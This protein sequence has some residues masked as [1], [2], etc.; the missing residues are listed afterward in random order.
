MATGE[1][2]PVALAALKA[3]H[4]YRN[5]DFTKKQ[6]MGFPTYGIPEQIRTWRVER[7]ML[8]LPRGG[9]KR[10]RT[11]LRENNLAFRVI[12]GRSEGTPPAHRLKYKGLP[13]REH[14]R[15]MVRVG[16]KDEQCIL[17]GATG[18]GK[19]IAAFALAAEIGL[20]TL[21]V[22]PNKALFKQWAHWADKVLGLRGDELG[23][24]GDG[25][26]RLRTLTIAIQDTLG[27]WATH[28]GI[29][30]DVSEF[31]GAII[32]D[33]I[34]RAAANTLYNAI[35][36]MPCR[37]RIGFSASEKRKD[38]KECLIYDLFSSVGYEASRSEMTAAGHILD[39][40]FRLIPT[41]FR[42]DWYG[43]DKGDLDFN[44]LLDEMTNDAKRNELAYRFIDAELGKGE[45]VL[46]FTHRREHA[47]DV[48]R[49][50]VGQ[51]VPSG[52]ML[53]DGEPGDAPE[54]DRTKAGIESGKVRCA[55]GTYSAIGVG[56]D[57]PAVGVGFALTPIHTNEQ[58][59][60]QVRGRLCRP[61][62]EAGKK[63]GCLYA[64]VDI[65]VFGLQPIRN[66]VSWNQ[67]VSVWDG[68]R[69]VDAKAYLKSKSKRGGQSFR[70]AS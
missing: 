50:F 53:G 41:S 48:D 61:N 16:M 64:L 11:I 13:L 31:F 55:I 15:E 56:I 4:E 1:L 46:S 5:P 12:D 51:G 32:G 23:M 9:M 42:A 19:T 68:K 45:Q 44:R 21:I 25:K 26:K 14:Q 17:R 52:M 54:F 6:S 67:R 24:I 47:R 36:Q 39:V 35:D 3:A 69:Y 7:D 30:E 29:P 62:P 18:S 60:N 37:Y 10:V 20:N 27:R 66:F 38:R 43:K 65:N 58:T 63:M 49:R 34:Q 8:T 33:E 40:E 2:T 22:L 57:L 59:T 70:R 28:G